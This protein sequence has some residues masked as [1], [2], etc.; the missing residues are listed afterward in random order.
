MDYRRADKVWRQGLER[1]TNEKELKNLNVKYVII[2]QIENGPLIAT[3]KVEDILKKVDLCVKFVKNYTKQKVDCGN[4]PKIAEEKKLYQR[5]QKNVL[6][7]LR[8][9]HKQKNLHWQKF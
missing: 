5:K 9:L 6:Q 2:Q 3:W 8:K 4:T 7:F 1:I